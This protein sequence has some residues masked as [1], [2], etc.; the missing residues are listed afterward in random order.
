[1]R[2]LLQLNQVGAKLAV[3]IAKLMIGEAEGR[4]YQTNAQ[5]MWKGRRC[6]SYFIFTSAYFVGMLG[7][8]ILR[9]L[10]SCARG[11]R[12][13]SPSPSYASDSKS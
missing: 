9:P 12:P 5:K 4:Q 2:F 6:V 11:R 3:G 8:V 7:N 1:M 10:K 13:Q